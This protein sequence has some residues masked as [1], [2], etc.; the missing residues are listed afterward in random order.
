LWRP[1][2]IL[3]W[4][5]PGAAAA[6]AAAAAARRPYM[7]RGHAKEVAQQ[8]NAAKQAA[9]KKSGT[10]KASQTLT[11][12]RSCERSAALHPNTPRSPTQG[13]AEKKLN[14]LCPLCKVR[15]PRLVA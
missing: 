10:Q 5:Q 4:G 6:A 2:E 12:V 8:K 3:L 9:L 15:L 7:V 1:G 14:F 11:H 13:A